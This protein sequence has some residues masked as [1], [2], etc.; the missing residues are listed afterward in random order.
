D[1][2]LMKERRTNPRA[3]CALV[4]AGFRLSPGFCRVLIRACCNTVAAGVDCNEIGWRDLAKTNRRGHF[5][6]A[7]ALEVKVT[8]AKMLTLV[9]TPCGLTCWAA[10]A[11]AVLEVMEALLAMSSASPSGSLSPAT[12]LAWCCWERSSFILCGWADV[13]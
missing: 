1:P 11:W 5:P 10:G 7:G 6:G 3:A 13:E 12:S 9:P 2:R 8:Y 4:L